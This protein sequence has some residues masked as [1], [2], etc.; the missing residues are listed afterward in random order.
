[1]RKVTV[2]MVV[3]GL[4]TA[5]GMA[6]ERIRGLARPETEATNSFYVGNRPPLLPSPLV[7]LPIGAIKPEG[8]LHTQLRLQADGFIGHLPEIS[9]FLEKDDNAWRAPDGL[10]EHGWE[11]VPYWLKGFGDM[12]Y[13]LQ[14]L[15]VIAEARDWIEAVLASQ[16]DDGYFGPHANLTRLDGKPDLWPNM[17]MLDA[18]RSYY[19]YTGDE[20]VPAWMAAYF[21]WEL[22]VPEEDFLLPFWQQ[23][24]AADNLANV[25]WLY[26]L[27]GESWLLELAEK[28]HRRTADWTGGVANWHGVN[29][30]QGFR[31]P[32]VYYQQSKDP[33]HL[34]ATERD[35]AEVMGMYGQV[36]G[37][38]FGADENCRPGFTGPRQAAETCT[39]VEFMLSFENLLKITGEPLWADRCEEV[40]FNSLPA[41]MTPDLK[42]LHYLTAPNL[43]RCDRQSKSPGVEN[44]GDMFSFN[45]HQ[46]RCCQHNVSHGWPYYAEHLWLATPDEGLAAVLYA[47]SR[48]RAKVAGGSEVTIS[49]ETRYPFDEL[50]LLT[51][52]TPEPVRFSLYLRRPAWCTAPTLKINGDERPWPEEPAAYAVIE[53]TWTEGDRLELRLPMPLTVKRWPKSHNCASVQRGPLTY[54]LKI[55]EEWERAGGTDEWPGFE[56]LPTTPW[57]YGLVL[58]K[59]DPTS[60]LK[61]LPRPERWADQ[62]FTPEAAVIELEVPARRIR[63]WQEDYWGLVGPL[64]DSP[65]R[66]N[67]PVEMVML[68]P[69]GCA[70]LRIA[71]FPVI[72]SGPEAVIWKARPERKEPLPASASHCYEGDSLGALSDGLEPKSSKDQTIPRFTWWDR[73]GSVEWVQYD[74][75]E[76]RS[77][78]EAEVYWFDDGPE[79]GCRPPASWR[80]L[81]RV[82]DKWQP[83]S[84]SMVY[85]VRRNRFNKIE[86]KPVTTTAVRIEVELRDGFSGGILEW[87]IASP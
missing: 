33:A 36:P 69:M 11:E 10:G 64:Q 28:I 54:A 50:V 55:G 46:Y 23:Q 56:L 20:R 75:A 2:M 84:G 13:V 8:W 80:L 66:S 35:Y 5:A 72:G 17:I 43:V 42:A 7:K 25:Y 51:V 59:E 34:A 61:V 60:T 83:V 76:P 79:G 57:N 32:A 49:E 37:G 78:S 85:G 68:I 38:M 44:G 27:T 86:F 24:R 58:D 48:V 3:L 77:V 45:P 31:G 47:P 16:Q 82:R 67:E 29:I 53:R 39:M 18:I 22:A 21:R 12:G 70:R 30:A 87:R 74:F 26:N 40:A 65:V 1:M 63:A 41:S 4:G 81:Y 6:D 73:R 14:D 52:S 71:A 9:E 15:H 19:E 62:P